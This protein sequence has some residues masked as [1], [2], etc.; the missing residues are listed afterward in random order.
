[1]SPV[2]TDDDRRRAPLVL[3]VS[4]GALRIDPG[5][6]G[7]RLMDEAPEGELVVQA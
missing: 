3:Q 6:M 7:V 2:R 1:M 5:G 4:S